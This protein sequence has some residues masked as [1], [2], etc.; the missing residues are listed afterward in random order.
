M[1]HLRNFDKNVADV[2]RE[3]LKMASCSDMMLFSEELNRTYS[4]KRLDDLAVSVEASKVDDIH[5]A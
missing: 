2:P 5:Y 4:K 1:G 3:W